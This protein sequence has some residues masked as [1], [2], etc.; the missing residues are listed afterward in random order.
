VWELNVKIL[1]GF[2]DVRARGF[3][4]FAAGVCVMFIGNFVTNELCNNMNLAYMMSR[5]EG[6][7]LIT[8]EN[9]LCEK[10]VELLQH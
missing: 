9:Q 8:N 2:R 6:L 7:V 10:D 3:R 5:N 1:N 4:D